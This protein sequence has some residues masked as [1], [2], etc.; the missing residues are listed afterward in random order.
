MA[1]II[2]LTALFAV[3]V[4]LVMGLWNM[5]KDGSKNRSQHLMRMRVALQAVAIAIAVG[6][7]MFA[8]GRG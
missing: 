8:T 6:F 4:V 2:T 1:K 5:L 7:L 3:A